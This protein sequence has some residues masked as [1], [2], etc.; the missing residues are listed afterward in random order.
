[1]YFINLLNDSEGIK[2]EISLIYISFLI[3]PIISNILETLII[4]RYKPEYINLIII[5]LF[6]ILYYSLI[7]FFGNMG[8]NIGDFDSKNLIEIKFIIKLF[9][10]SL[11]G[12]YGGW[13][14]YKYITKPKIKKI[15][16]DSSVDSNDLSEE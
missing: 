4:K 14:L 16:L 2:D 9:I 6:L 7:H 15:N 3:S 8:M 13:W 5:I 1:M 12:S 10:F 11:I